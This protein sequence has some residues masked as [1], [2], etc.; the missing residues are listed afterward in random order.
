MFDINGK[1]RFEIIRTIAL[2]LII[3]LLCMTSVIGVTWALFT[4]G[5][6]GSIGVNV[7]SG[8]VKLD[9]VDIKNTS[10]KGQYLH[11]TRDSD[12]KDLICEPG[13]SF[14]TQGF[15]IVNKGTVSANFRIFVRDDGDS[16]MLEFEKAFEIWITDNPTDPTNA[17]RLQQF[18]GTLAPN[19][20][21][22]VYFLV[23]KMKPEIGNEFQQAEYDGIGVTVFGVQ[24]NVDIDNVE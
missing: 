18:T 19:G 24:S 12:S 14:Y 2:P 8:S 20:E 11:F 7:S 17:V 10:L 3:I 4:S 1:S 16:N 6:D 5:E 15:K 21:T 9:I 13:A 23:I 22:G